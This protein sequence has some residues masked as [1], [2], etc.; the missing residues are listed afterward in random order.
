M[1]LEVSGT[2]VDP[3]FKKFLSRAISIRIGFEQASR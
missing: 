2:L 3:R 1:K